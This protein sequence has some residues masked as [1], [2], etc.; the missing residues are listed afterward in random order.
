MKYKEKINLLDKTPNQPSKF[1]TKKRAKQNDVSRG[2]YNTNS[3]IKLE[4][5]FK[6][7]LCDYSDAYILVKGIIT[8]I[9]TGKDDAS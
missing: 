5:I 4:T 6:I 3:Q 1:S 7:C 9:D 8:V 2:T